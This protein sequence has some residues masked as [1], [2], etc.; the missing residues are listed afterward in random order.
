MALDREDSPQN[1]HASSVLLSAPPHPTSSAA[2]RRRRPPNPDAGPLRR[3]APLPFSAAVLDFQ[4]NRRKN[5]SQKSWTFGRPGNL[6][7]AAALLNALTQRQGLA[8]LR[9]QLPSRDRSPF[10]ADEMDERKKKRP[11]SPSRF[12]ASRFSR[13]FRARRPPRDSFLASRIGRILSRLSSPRL[14]RSLQNALREPIPDLISSPRHSLFILRLFP[15]EVSSTQSLLGNLFQNFLASPSPFS[16]NQ[17][18]SISKPIDRNAH[19]LNELFAKI[20]VSSRYSDLCCPRNS[21]E[22]PIVDFLIFG[23]TRS[24]PPRFSGSNSVFPSAGR[25]KTRGRAASGADCSSLNCGRARRI[26]LSAPS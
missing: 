24:F 15:E 13:P 23:V 18:T 19:S 1:T 2:R 5:Q 22:K 26:G 20:T 8:P 16:R 25:T 9:L 6:G 10:P 7:I 3:R 21:S 4:R 12:L 11:R 17:K 14:L